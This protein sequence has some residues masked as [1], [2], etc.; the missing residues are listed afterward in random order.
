MLV[1][2]VPIVFCLALALSPI[3]AQAGSEASDGEKA[4]PVAAASP[5]TQDGKVESAAADTIAPGTTITMQNWRNYQQ[6]MPEGMAGLFEGKY[7]W[8][9]PDDVSME[10]GPTVINE[11]PANYLAA[12]EKYSGQVK[13][14]ELPSGGL[15]LANYQGGIPF[16]TPAEPHKGWKILANLWFR[17][18]PHVAVD[19]YGQGCYVD[20]YHNVNCNAGV[21]VFRQLSFNTD[22]GV[23]A[24]VPGGVG[25][26]FTDYYEAEEPEN[27]RYEANLKIDYTDLA[28]PEDSYVFIPSLRRYQ[29]VSALARCAP[30]FG[31][32][33]PEDF[34]GG[35][36][37]NMTEVKVDFL[38]QKKILNL[39]GFTMP[40]TGFP[41]N[42]D[43]PLGW[44]KPSWGKWQLRDVD[45]VSVAKLPQ[46]A[47]GYCYGKRV[48]YIDK[49]FYGLLWQDL[50]DEQEQPW[51]FV[52][53]FRPAHEAP[54][55][56]P[57]D[58]A[59]SYDESIWDIQ[60]QHATFF[61]DPPAGH[62]LYLNQQSPPSYL[63][64]NRY[65]TPSGLSLIMR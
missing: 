49:H 61:C 6:F 29:P 10:V 4:I 51:K 56:G 46:L 18:V 30:S 2:R 7:F 27:E 64:L 25:K 47:K 34:R 63:D 48:M 62:P 58:E 19:T 15:T 14:V 17:Y 59:L 65:T 55:I 36:D 13:V 22:P 28:R 37:S 16:P 31:D 52:A 41:D 11:L 50:Y 12:T 3:L 23:P 53:V 20:S 42:F 35:Y 40:S 32:T 9:M 60:K 43:M 26:F 45:V 44:P 5:A 39:I 54:G 24:T 8:K 38:G 1:S 33:T 57:V 21:L